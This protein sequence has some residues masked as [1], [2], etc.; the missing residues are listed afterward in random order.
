M[1]SSDRKIIRRNRNE[2]RNILARIDILQII[3]NHDVESR[4]TGD[5]KYDKVVS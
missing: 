4:A 1:I 5:V 2:N 3:I